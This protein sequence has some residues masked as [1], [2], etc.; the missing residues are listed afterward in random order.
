MNRVSTV[1][2]ICNTL[3]YLGGY[4]R[5][6]AP[7]GFTISEVIQLIYVRMFTDEQNDSHETVEEGRR[8]RV[9][10]LFSESQLAVLRHHYALDPRPRREHLLGLAQQ[11]V[12]P[13]RVVQVRKRM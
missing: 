12:L 4:L 7:L 1:S 11:L 2:G 10:S 8:A 13:L 5:P 6:P 9:R 3:E